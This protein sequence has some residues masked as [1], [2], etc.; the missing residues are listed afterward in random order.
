MSNKAS[1][2]EQ[3]QPGV[4]RFVAERI[5][6]GVI[7][8][9]A[10]GTPISRELLRE[11]ATFG[12]LGAT[13]PP[14]V[15]GAGHDLERWGRSL[16]AIGY[17]CDDNSFP[18]LISLFSAVAQTVYDTG[19]PELVERYVRPAAQGERLLS[20]AW[21]ENADAFS[22][23]SNARR[24]GDEYVVNGEKFLVTGGTLA[25]AYMLYLRDER[26]D[27]ITLLIDRDLPGVTVT[28]VPTMGMRAAGL[29]SLR[30]EAVRVPVTQ[31]LVAHDG[32]GHVQRFLNRRRVI[33]TCGFLGRMRA[34]LEQTVQHL[35][36]TIRYGMPLTTMQTVQAALGRLY[37]HV[38]TAQV[39]MHRALAQLGQGVYVPEWDVDL[40]IAKYFLIE[41][42]IEVAE[43]ALRLSGGRGYVTTSN[44]ERN[45]RDFL[46]FLAGAGAQDILEVDI[47]NWLISET[48]RG[49]LYTI[50][51][52]TAKVKPGQPAS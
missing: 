33:V 14:E 3:A 38:Q 44:V 42:T 18:L 31:Q 2:M 34:L 11:A 12:L 50:P 48:Q 1:W 29:A 45:L 13:L 5:N 32:I 25:D 40:S 37:V 43:G 6:P 36:Q 52:P 19:R 24:V 16:E 4:A 9:D 46:G 8:R 47:G 35:D 7:E 49:A 22:F 30:L 27:V 21:T 39:V 15:G 10:A 20:F 17:L 41:R 26:N 51:I 28:P 23:A